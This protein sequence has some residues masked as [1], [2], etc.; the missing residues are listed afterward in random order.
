M[1]L[2]FPC[3]RHTINT[4]CS[5]ASLPV[6]KRNRELVLTVPRFTRY[7][8]K[9]CRKLGPTQHRSEIFFFFLFDQK[10]DL[11]DGFLTVIWGVRGEGEKCKMSCIWPSWT[12]TRRIEIVKY[13]HMFCSTCLVYVSSRAGGSSGHSKMFGFAASHSKRYLDLN[14]S[15][16]PPGSYFH[17]LNIQW[18][19]VGI[20]RRR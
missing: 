10:T 13:P 18:Q 9:V 19:V 1:L 20:S 12:S 11:A 15:N 4:Q 14:G 2:L 17:T 8:D 7:F 5:C 16:L 3:I 6:W